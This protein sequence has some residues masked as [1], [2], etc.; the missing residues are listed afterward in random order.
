MIHFRFYYYFYLLC[1][2]APRKPN[3]PAKAPQAAGDSEAKGKV[4]PV[5]GASSQNNA[6]K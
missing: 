6:G 1:C 5:A 4:A 3:A 2:S